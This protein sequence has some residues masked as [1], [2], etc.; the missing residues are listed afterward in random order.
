MSAVSTNILLRDSNVTGAPAVS[1]KV[2]KL[3]ALTAREAAALCRSGCDRNVG[4]DYQPTN[5]TVT[6]SQSFK[7]LT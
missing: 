7:A 4:V 2:S 6:K 3:K 5:S 1:K